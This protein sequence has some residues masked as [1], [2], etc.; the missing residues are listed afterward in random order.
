[1]KIKSI[2]LVALASLF[3]GIVAI[4]GANAQSTLASKP[5]FYIAEFEVTDPEGIKPY[6]AQ[7]ESSFTPFG[8]HFIVRGGPIAPL[9]GDAPKGRL[10]IIEFENM[11]KAQAWYNSPAYEKLKPIRFRTAKSRVLIVEGISQ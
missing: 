2:A 3:V 8:G 9:E 7:V 10:V 5:A 6:S 4:K 11:E 1:M